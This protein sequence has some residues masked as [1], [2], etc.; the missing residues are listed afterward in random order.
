M[1]YNGIGRLT[2]YSKVCATGC[3]CNET[4]IGII[5]IIIYIQVYACACQKTVNITK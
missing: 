3:D 4:F 2:E 1:I 5:I